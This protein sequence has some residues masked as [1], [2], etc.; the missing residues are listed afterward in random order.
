MSGES[1][2][3]PII[4]RGKRWLGVRTQ[5]QRTGIPSSVRRV[6]PG[7][8]YPLGATWDGRGVNFA[9]YAEHATKVELCLFDSLDA[10]KE[11]ERIPLPEQSDMVWHVYLPDVTPQ[12]LYGYR[13]H[14]P[15]EPH[16]GHRFNANKILVDPYAKLIARRTRWHDSLFAYQI[17]SPEADLSFNDQDSAPYAPLSAVV[18]PAFT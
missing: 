17:G 15:Y 11:S 3:K 4:G 5:E 10:E 16:H 7:K 1:E 2:K 8:P 13:V 12:Q 18:D 14:G 9:I 6:W